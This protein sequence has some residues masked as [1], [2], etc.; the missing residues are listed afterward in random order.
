MNADKTRVTGFKVLEANHADFLEPT[1]GV[2]VNDSFYY[3]AN[4]QWPLIDEKGVLKKEKLREPVILRL[5][6]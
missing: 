2:I 1:L 6:L 5:K 4:S 3:I